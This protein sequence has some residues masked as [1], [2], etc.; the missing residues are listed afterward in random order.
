M[1]NKRGESSWAK[2]EAKKL[3]V[4]KLKVRDSCAN[5]LPPLQTLYHSLPSSV[6]SV[7][8]LLS[9]RLES[10]IALCDKLSVRV[11]E[12]SPPLVTLDECRLCMDHCKVATGSKQWGS[13][14]EFLKGKGLLDVG[15][16]NLVDYRGLGIEAQRA[17]KDG[18]RERGDWWNEGGGRFGG[19]EEKKEAAKEQVRVDWRWEGGS[20]D[21]LPPSI[22]NNDSPAPLTRHSVASPHAPTQGTHGSA[23]GLGGS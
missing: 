3:R 4:R 11:G 12:S 22:P 1:P 17:G 15:D 18:E 20:R 8:L 16:Q 10:F 19:F 6:H 9:P 5:P 21:F 7:L 14:K 13:F 23:Q 2:R